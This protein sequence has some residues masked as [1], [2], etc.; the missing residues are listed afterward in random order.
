M[1]VKVGLP[2]PQ[3]FLSEFPTREPGN[4]SFSPF[5]SRVG[6]FDGRESAYAAFVFDGGLCE[7]SSHF[8]SMS[9]IEI[10]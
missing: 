9:L 6:L 1:R 2:D 4:R 3:E 10:N 7:V 8:F 5:S